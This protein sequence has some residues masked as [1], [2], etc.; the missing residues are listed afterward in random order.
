[1]KINK[2]RRKLARWFF[3]SVTLMLL[4]AT[5]IVAVEATRPRQF[6]GQ[7]KII[8]DPKG[9][10]NAA[11]PTDTL[12]ANV[13]IPFNLLSAA[14]SSSLA[15]KFAWA[16][17]S[18]KGRQASW[19]L[20]QTGQVSVNPGQGTIEL[21]LPFTA[22]LNGQTFLVPITLTTES[23]T[24][25]YGPTSGKRAIAGKLDSTVT[26]VGGFQ[27]DIDKKKLDPNTTET[28]TQTVIFRAVVDGRFTS[29]SGSAIF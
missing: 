11:A 4:F 15:S 20:G 7:I 27:A 14:T 16:G 28:G 8:C 23:E 5:V 19:S 25:G 9:K 18:A 10:T 2:T 24:D 26:L 12:T 21:H 3:A 1:M 22:S 6:Q 13:N 17:L 29:P